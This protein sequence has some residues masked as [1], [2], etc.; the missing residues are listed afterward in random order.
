MAMT[1]REEPI[2]ALSAGLSH[3]MLTGV[4]LLVALPGH[5]PLRELSPVPPPVAAP[6]PSSPAV[7][8][9]GAPQP[10]SS[11]AE[12]SPAV[13]TADVKDEWP[14]EEVVRGRE[15]CMHLLSGMAAEFEM[16]ESI[17]KG[18]C[19]LPAPV[20]LKS[21]GSDPKVVFDP[22]VQVNCRMVAALGKWAKT[23]LQPNA[24]A[25]FSSSVTRVVGASGYSCRNI[26]NLPNARLSQHALANAIDIGGF[27]L[28]NGRYISVLK[29]WGPTVR[30]IQA[31]A[32]RAKAKAEAEAKRKDKAK[33]GDK[34]QASS[35]STVA[36]AKDT[37]ATEAVAGRREKLAKQVTQASLTPI[38]QKPLLAQKKSAVA[39]EPAEKPAE[40]QKPTKEA[41]FLRSIHG[42][43]CGEFGTVMGP[44]ANDPHRNHFHLDLI[45]RRGRGYCE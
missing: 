9:P 30:D 27:G 17:K 28:A 38:P 33:A 6:A 2:P 42:G 39:A 25:R 24:R 32:K 20:L 18:E 15:Q 45:S 10:A 26:Y 44:E 35:N 14:Q 12:P 5:P 23:T 36:E 8:S 43:A 13:E 1:R 37:A 7:V 19:G 11:A 29:G 16:M 40:A 22:P 21:I 31:A 34:E 41:Q 4:F 3:L